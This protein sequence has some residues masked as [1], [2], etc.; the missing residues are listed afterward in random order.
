MNIVSRG[1]I[2]FLAVLLGLSGSLWIDNYVKE[3]EHKEENK[4]I[5][6][7]LYNNMVADSIDGVWNKNAYER[8]IKGSNNVIKWCDSNPNYSMINDSIE[9][10]ISAMVIGVIFVNNEE[11]YNALKNSGRMDLLDNEDLIIN[12]H[13]YYTNL[14][15]VK[16]IDKHQV[17]SIFN[18][19][20]PFLQN[21]SDEFL[22][23]E[24][25][26]KNKIYKNFPK[27]N[28][29]ELPDTKKLRFFATQ[30]LYWQQFSYSR[31][32]SI[33]NNVTEIRRLL[34]E[35]LDL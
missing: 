6:K 18:N 27:I 21:Y 33:V 2:E 4:K 15:F 29:F 16:E 35:E 28:L 13:K 25:N 17:N 32:N 10:D 26:L 1:G 12:L 14:R 11:E 31:Y 30:M 7:R 5:L 9:K 19:I 3:K 23:D 24:N 22:Y 20:I 34:R 8:A